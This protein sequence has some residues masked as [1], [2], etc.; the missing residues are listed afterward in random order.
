MGSAEVSMNNQEAFDRALRGIRAQ[1]YRQSLTGTGCAYRG[2]N[3]LKCAIGHCIDDDELARRM[4]IGHATSITALLNSAKHLN[5][6]T[7]FKDCDERLL[8]RLQHAHDRIRSPTPFEDEMSLIAAH[9]NL[10]YQKP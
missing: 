4:D 8:L 2:E 6:N 1:G 10:S 5:L 9:H 3:G 7:L